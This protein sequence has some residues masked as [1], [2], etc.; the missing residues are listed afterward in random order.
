MWYLTI[1]KAEFLEIYKG[2]EVV[3]S[4]GLFERQPVNDTEAVAS[5]FPSK[6]W[7][8]NNWYGIR[9][10]FGTPMKFNMNRAQHLTYAAILKHTRLIIL[11]SRQQR[12]INLLV[13]VIL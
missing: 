12:H 6:L 2:T 10:K 7:R 4:V 9:D 8:L 1:S 5:Y 13:G 11:K 3:K